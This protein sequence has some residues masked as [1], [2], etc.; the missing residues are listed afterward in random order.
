MLQNTAETNYLNK[1]GRLLEISKKGG[2]VPT[3]HDS[4]TFLFYKGISESSKMQRNTFRILCELECLRH[5]EISK[6]SCKKKNMIGLFSFFSHYGIPEKRIGKG[7]HLKNSKKVECSA[8]AITFSL[9]MYSPFSFHLANI[10]TKLETFCED[11]ECFLNKFCV[12]KKICLTHV[13]HINDDVNDEIIH[14]SR[15][16]DFISHK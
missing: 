16:D 6:W 5:G 9:R 10:V 1:N 11:G 14:L 7:L 8:C 2:L 13:N 12:I 15:V 3:N 4:K